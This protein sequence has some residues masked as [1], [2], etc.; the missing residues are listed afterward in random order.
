MLLLKNNILLVTLTSSLLLMSCARPILVVQTST[1]DLVLNIEEFV[2][3]S[4]DLELTYDYWSPDGV[5]FISMLNLTEDTVFLDLKD[6]HFSQRLNQ[7]RFDEILGFYDSYKYTTDY[8]DL[9]FRQVDGKI[10]LVLPPAQWASFYGP[11]CHDMKSIRN[12]DPFTFNYVYQSKLVEKRLTHRF[13]LTEIGRLKRTEVD[14]YERQS[15]GPN[16]YYIDQDPHGFQ[17]E[18]GM[19]TTQ[20]ILDLLLSLIFI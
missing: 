17:D 3:Q 20:V 4:S 10:L 2:D 8:S 1:S 6:S 11:S 5:P 12:G 18:A 7:I 16:L 15:A 14:S 19:V 9:L 13:N